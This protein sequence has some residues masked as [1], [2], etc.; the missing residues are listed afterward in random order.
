MVGALT[1]ETKSS[2]D[3]VAACT[4]EQAQSEVA[5]ERA[6]AGAVPDMNEARILVQRNILGAIES[7]LD[8]PM[9]AS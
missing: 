4:M 8:E 3:L 1:M 2:R 6:D 9:P 5:K 7:I